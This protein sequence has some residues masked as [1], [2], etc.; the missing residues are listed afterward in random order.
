MEDRDRLAEV[1]KHADRVER[2]RKKRREELRQRTKSYKE[3][4]DDVKQEHNVILD[5]AQQPPPY[6]PSFQ[7]KGVKKSKPSITWSGKDFPR[8]GDKKGEEEQDRKEES[9]EEEE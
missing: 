9:G 3:L 7:A 2:L 4:T 6:N 1:F 8:H 5:A